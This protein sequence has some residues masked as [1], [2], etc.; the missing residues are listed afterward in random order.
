MNGIMDLNHDY[1]RLLAI[2][3]NLS[4]SVDIH[5][6]II[7]MM[8]FL[9]SLVET[10]THQMVFS[11]YMCVLMMVKIIETEYPMLLKHKLSIFTEK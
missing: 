6:L 3:I 10:I 5:I 2:H 11:D 1:F 8:V 7:I 4:L 9:I